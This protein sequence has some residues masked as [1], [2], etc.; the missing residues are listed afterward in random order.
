VASRTF[1]SLQYPGTKRYFAGLT[2]SMCGSWVQS[3]ALAWLILKE[4]DGAG[5]ELGWQQA[6]Q[7][8]PIL[9]LG[10]WAGSLA[11]RID[12]R[13]LM[14][15]TQVA[16]AACAFLLGW[17][18]LADRAS[19]FAVL[20]VSVISGVA[21][22]FDTPV[23]RSLIGD[24]VPKESISNAMALNTG[25]ITASR[26]VGMS[27]GGLLVKFVG[28][29]WCFMI[30]GLSYAGMLFALI[31][32]GVRGHQ[33][34]KATDSGVKDGFVHVWRTPTLRVAMLVT[35]AIATFTFNYGLTIPLIV[36]KVFKQG[37]DS[38][39]ALMAVTSVGSF[40]GAMVTARRGTPTL[41]MLFV[42]GF[43]MAAATVALGAAPTLIVAAAM[44]VPMGF[45]GG[46]FMSQLT[47]LLTSLSPSDMRGRVLALQTV[48]FIGSTP[49]GSPIIGAVADRFGP[50]W[51]AAFGG[52]V[53]G[54]AV[55]TAIPMWVRRRRPEHS[56]MPA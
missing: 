13:R 42:G 27:I 20:V 44:S 38:F 17:L 43:M 26:V 46:L 8:L 18:A 36:E 1:A 32:L 3:I 52:L 4:L 48:V 2:V 15:V 51:G 53:G 7:F 22:A 37:A 6:S 34:P 28:T 47:G 10:A 31:G 29:G 16:M 12:K 49:I 24:L 50:R 21:S 54:A 23:R 35:V 55:L 14:F 11:D 56:A 39:G 5:R 40:L 41:R 25:V 30:N 45:G 19:L 33:S 9:L